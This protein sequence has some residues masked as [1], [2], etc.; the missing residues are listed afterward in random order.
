MTVKE[1]KQYL[2]RFDEEQEL[3][4]IMVDP[5]HRLHHIGDC[6][7]LLDESPCLLLET[8]ESEPLED[9]SDEEEV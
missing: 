6:I 1:F 2:S 8:T 4:V 3:S 7:G 9:A 5:V